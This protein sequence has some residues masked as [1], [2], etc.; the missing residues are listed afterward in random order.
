MAHESGFSHGWHSRQGQSLSTQSKRPGHTSPTSLASYLPSEPLSPISDFSGSDRAVSDAPVIQEKEFSFRGMRQAPRDA[1][2]TSDRYAATGQYFASRAEPRKEIFARRQGANSGWS[3][4]VSDFPQDY[5]SRGNSD[6]LGSQHSHPFEG[7][8]I[9]RGGEIRHTQADTIPNERVIYPNMLDTHFSTVPSYSAPAWLGQSNFKPSTAPFAFKPPQ[10]FSRFAPSARKKAHT[11]LEVPDPIPNESTRFRHR[12]A[13]GQTLSSPTP[14]LYEETYEML[15]EVNVAPYFYPKQSSG[16]VHELEARELLPEEPSLTNSSSRNPYAYIPLEPQSVSINF[17]TL[18]DFLPRSE[19][20]GKQASSDNSKEG[21]DRK[22][23]VHQSAE[24]QSTEF[25]SVD[26]I[27]ESSESFHSTVSSTFT[28]KNVKFDNFYTPANE[29]F[30]NAKPYT[31]LNQGLKEIRLLRVSPR[32]SVAQQYKMRPNWNFSH[33][34][35]L[36][37]GESLIACD[38]VKTSLTRIADN[39]VT[40]SYCAGDPKKT[41]VILVDGIPF[42]AFANLE[43]AIDRVMTHWMMHHPDGEP[44]LL[45]ADQ[46]SINQ[47][48]KDERSNQVQIMRDIYRRSCETY[49]CLSEPQLENCLAWVP[50][51][52]ASPNQQS[53]RVVE[54]QKLLLDVFIGK[55][56]ARHLLSTSDSVLK[57]QFIPRAKGSLTQISRKPVNLQPISRQNSLLV[58]ISERHRDP[59]FRLPGALSRSSTKTNRGEILDPEQPRISS[60]EF[61]SS[62]I[63]FMTNKW[64]RRYVI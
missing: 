12:G 22:T 60:A 2:K 4:L 31:T 63:E 33:A 57:T 21:D 6:Y 35:D 15:S 34:R 8:P 10:P 48:D 62:L 24:P 55:E 19:R 37:K 27:T 49:V 50:R 44:L 58:G 40:L 5:H 32:K 59:K 9:P 61:Q 39:F 43:H 38:I 41:A 3:A 28:D 17:A 64:W 13:N 25:R 53:N 46:I 45:W 54:L 23:S 42:N 11:F 7:R 18:P 16:F 14:M 1:T 56:N 26:D 52:S 20:T 47:S 51:E 30:Y 29:Q 36:A